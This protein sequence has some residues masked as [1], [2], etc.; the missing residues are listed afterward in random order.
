MLSD[1]LITVDLNDLLE[2]VNNHYIDT[3]SSKSWLFMNA[4]SLMSNRPRVKN[5]DKQFL[6]TAGKRIWK[7][8]TSPASNWSGA[9]DDVYLFVS[10]A[11]GVP[12]DS[13][14]QW[15]AQNISINKDDKVYGIRL[16]TFSNVKNNPVFGQS[17][18][19]PKDSDGRFYMWDFNKD[20]KLVPIP[21]QLLKER[22]I[23]W[24]DS[25]W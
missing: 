20:D 14:S 7:P 21:T 12:V 4:V 16:R 17:A 19:L 3:G 2:A 11:L 8:S 24:E 10:G 5:F 23:E 1:S 6:A 13:I 9:L 18:L 22:L 15:V 25:V